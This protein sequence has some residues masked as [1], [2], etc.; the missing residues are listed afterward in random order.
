MT[1]PGSI[2]KKYEHFNKALPNWDSKDGK[3]ISSRAHYEKELQKG[4]FE[5]Y[6]GKG[7]Y[8]QKKWTP[9]VEIKKDLYQLKQM[10]GRDG[11]ID[12]TNREGVKKLME[13]T[14]V[15]F[16]EVPNSI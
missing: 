4:G 6:N 14:G 2:V 13:K 9:S 11:K 12:A 16:R 5:P 15:K 8:E 3:Y 10:G 7:H 1:H